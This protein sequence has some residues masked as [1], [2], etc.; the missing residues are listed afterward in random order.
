MLLTK[1]KFTY[2][3]PQ[4]VHSEHRFGSDFAALVFR[5]PS[6]NTP[7]IECAGYKWYAVDASAVEEAF[8]QVALHTFRYFASINPSLLRLPIFK[9]P[10]VFSGEDGV[11]MSVSS[12][13]S[14]FR[15]SE[16]PT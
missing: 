4:G 16:P 7:V 2:S 11:R 14:V 1:C 5:R 15:D 6:L 12:R 3:P 8:G 13:L 9:I 10:L